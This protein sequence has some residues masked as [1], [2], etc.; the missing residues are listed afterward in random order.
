MDI[1]PIIGLIGVVV[2]AV[3]AAVLATIKVK[4][5]RYEAE[6]KAEAKRYDDMFA[7]Y[8]TQADSQRDDLKAQLAKA[9]E[10]ADRHAEARVTESE[11][12]RRETVNLG[13]EA[14]KVVQASNAA[15]D[16]QERAARR[17]S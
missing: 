1:E 8:R 6:R 3:G 12:I 10:R 7:A 5:R 17:R 13:L 15:R 4:E 9:Q 11:R 2:P 16:E 14:L